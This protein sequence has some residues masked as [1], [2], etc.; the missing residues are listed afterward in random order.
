MTVA[1]DAVD[2]CCIHLLWI[3]Y[4]HCCGQCKTTTVVFCSLL[5]TCTKLPLL[6]ICTDSTTFICCIHCCGYI[7]IC[8]IHCRGIYMQHPL[9]WIY[10]PHPL[11][12]IY[13]PHPLLW[14]TRPFTTTFVVF[15][16]VHG[17]GS[18]LDFHCCGSE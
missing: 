2:I 12:W 8:N 3:Y 11:L 16:N 15:F 4:C 5:W 18:V 9:L 17:R 10:G 13:G 1:S 6:W 14:I 7:Y